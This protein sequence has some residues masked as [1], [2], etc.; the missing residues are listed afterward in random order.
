MIDKEED[1]GVAL[2]AEMCELVVEVE[3]IVVVLAFLW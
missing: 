1:E 3:G 2:G